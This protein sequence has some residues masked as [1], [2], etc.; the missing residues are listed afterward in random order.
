MNDPHSVYIPCDPSEATRYVTQN[1][2]IFERRIAD[3]FECMDPRHSLG[4]NILLAHGAEPQKVL[5]APEGKYVWQGK[6]DR[7]P[8]PLGT[9]LYKRSSWVELGGHAQDTGNVY[10]SPIQSVEKQD[11]VCK[12]SAASDLV[13]DC[14]GVQASGSQGS[15]VSNDR[16]RQI[17]ERCDNATPGTWAVADAGLGL[18]SLEVSPH[19][20]NGMV[21]SVDAEP[22]RHGYI[23]KSDVGGYARSRKEGI[24]NTHFIAHARQD[25]PWLLAEIERL[26][27][28]AKPSEPNSQEVTPSQQEEIERLKFALSAIEQYG[29]DTLSGPSNNEDNTREWQREGVREMVRRARAALAGEPFTPAK[30]APSQL[31][32]EV[33]EPVPERVVYG[34]KF[35]RCD[36]LEDAGEVAYLPRDAFIEGQQVWVSNFKPEIPVETPIEVGPGEGFRWVERG[37]VIPEGAQHRRRGMW[38]ESEAVGDKCPIQRTWRIPTVT[39]QREEGPLWKLPDTH[40][41][42]TLPTGQKLPEGSLCSWP[43]TCKGWGPASNMPVI[44]GPIYAIPKAAIRAGFGT[45]VIPSTPTEPN[46]GEKV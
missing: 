26:R 37:E 9:S 18:V 24:A 10:A 41:V 39:D 19:K 32:E 21:V 42:V 35:F 28:E 16:L 13:E 33:P 22:Q 14:A 17:Q 12:E 20:F 44:N 23:S 30:D 43:H 15:G 7:K 36:D 40:M 38:V 46:Q 3:I 27:S 11:S 4:G 45:Q 6:A 2:L 31:K 1:G 29:S 34:G 5:V 8:L 25:I